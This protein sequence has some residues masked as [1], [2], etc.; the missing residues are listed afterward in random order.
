MQSSKKTIWFDCLGS[1]QNGISVTVC[2]SS[3]TA[4]DGIFRTSYSL[5]LDVAGKALSAACH[6]NCHTHA[7]KKS[8]GITSTIRMGS[9]QN[10]KI[11]V[12]TFKRTTNMILVPSFPL[13]L[14]KQRIPQKRG[15]S[16]RKRR[17]ITG[18]IH[19][20]RVILERCQSKFPNSMPEVKLRPSVPSG[21]KQSSQQQSSQWSY[22]F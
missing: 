10:P 18:D 19:K 5:S 13:M 15:S 12:Q 21:A 6:S 3:V 14:K 11:H 20:L 1:A 17:C 2:N 9:N 22:I 16:L 8:H 7:Q 4:S